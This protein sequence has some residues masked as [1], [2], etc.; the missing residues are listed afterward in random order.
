MRA[1]DLASEWWKAYNT[2][3]ALPPLTHKVAQEMMA[4]LDKAVEKGAV[5][6]AAANLARIA[7]DRSR[8]F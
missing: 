4:L 5:A 1:H 7:I 2:G 6:I 3:R 8:R